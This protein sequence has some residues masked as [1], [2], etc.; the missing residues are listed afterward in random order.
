M[1]AIVLMAGHE[2]SVNQIGNTILALVNH[3]AQL[4]KVRSGPRLIPAAVEE[5]LRFDTPTP[6]GLRSALE[7]VEIGEVYVARGDLLLTGLGSAN[8]DPDLLDRPDAFDVTRRQGGRHLSFGQGIHFCSGAS[9]ARA[10]TR[11]V[12]DALLRTTNGI[13]L[14]VPSADL[15]H[16][17]TPF[18]RGL[19][20]LPLSLW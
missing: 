8:R 2:N 20:S 10:E 15:R 3:P 19:E 17:P 5:A 16:R 9:L 18:F 12:L 4:Q 7:D 6:Y 11:A 13:Q 1:A 14:S